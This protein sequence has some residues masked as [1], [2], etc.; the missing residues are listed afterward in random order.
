MM[1]GPM[2]SSVPPGHALRQ[3]AIEP[4]AP[5][6]FLRR[7]VLAPRGLT[8]TQA[9]EVFGLPVADMED[10]LEGKLKVDRAIAVKLGGGTGTSPGFWLNMQA[11]ADR[12]PGVQQPPG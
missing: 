11:A 2:R 7:R 5:G 3:A 8:A 9:A 12:D 1:E 4:P 6:A 10:L